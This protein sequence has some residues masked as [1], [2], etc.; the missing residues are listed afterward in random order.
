MVFIVIWAVAKGII[1]VKRDSTSSPVSE[2]TTIIQIV[3]T[4]SHYEWPVM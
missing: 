3:L 2:S 1:P 4:I